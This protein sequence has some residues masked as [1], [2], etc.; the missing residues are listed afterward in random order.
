VLK[1]DVDDV[2]R[3]TRDIHSVSESSSNQS[4][5][6]SDFY[7]IISD[8]WLACRLEIPNPQ[9]RTKTAMPRRHYPAELL[10]I[11]KSIQPNAVGT[12]STRKTWVAFDTATRVR[13]G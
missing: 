8:P 9:N 6:I 11:M 3:A 2:L 13:L 1:A 12:E 7:R 4:C 5:I 10:T